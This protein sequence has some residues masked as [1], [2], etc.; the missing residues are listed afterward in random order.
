VIR[1]GEGVEPR[2]AGGCDQ[3][4]RTAHAIGG[5]EGMNMK[6]DPEGHGMESGRCHVTSG[7]DKKT[8]KTSLRRPGRA[9]EAFF[10][11]ARAAHLLCN[12]TR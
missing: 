8:A 12:Q 10:R 1:H 6:I 3:I 4:L 5:K 7:W 2:R 11:L 9:G